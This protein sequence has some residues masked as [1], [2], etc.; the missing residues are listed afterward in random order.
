MN[1]LV[2]KPLWKYQ[3]ATV[4]SYGPKRFTF[5]KYFLSSV[6]NSEHVYQPWV[7]NLVNKRQYDFLSHRK[8][9]FSVSSYHKQ[10]QGKKIAKFKFEK[11]LES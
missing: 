6:V 11:N 4:V 7:N 3:T 5:K 9:R 10:I 8:Y 2:P 1:S